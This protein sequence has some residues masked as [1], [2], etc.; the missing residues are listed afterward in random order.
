MRITDEQFISAMEQ[1]VKEKGGDHVARATYFSGGAPR[2]IVGYAL[3]CID[4][5]ACPTTNML[6]ADALLPAMGVSQR[7]AKAAYAAQHLNDSEFEWKYVLQGFKDALMF[8]ESM[9][10][11]EAVYNVRARMER[12]RRKDKGIAEAKVVSGLS[13]GGLVPTIEPIQ[14]VP[15]QAPQKITINFTT[16]TN[17]ISTSLGALEALIQKM[18]AANAALTSPK[19]KDHDLVA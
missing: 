18:N 16:M 17:N 14:W 1:A 5:S 11:H 9:T 4:K 8:P 6:M 2:C 12:L 15:I 19:Q 13:N 3:W 7:V 10:Q